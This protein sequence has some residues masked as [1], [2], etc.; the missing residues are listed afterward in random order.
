MN[1]T[2]RGARDEF[3]R[4][5]VWARQLSSEGG[6]AVA[7]VRVYCGLA[8]VETDGPTR[9][10]ATRLAVAVVDDSGRLLDSCDISDTAA[11]YARLSALLSERSS[12]PATVAVAADSD[13]LTV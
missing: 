9:D 3:P 11:G 5:V 8:S 6:D 7:L 1:R 2:S 4:D 10:S 12:G 13:D